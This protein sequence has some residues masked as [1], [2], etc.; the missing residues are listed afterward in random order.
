MKQKLFIF[1]F[2][3]LY[4]FTLYGQTTQNSKVLQQK[5]QSADSVVLISHEITFGYAVT[6]EKEMGDTTTS[7][8][9]PVPAFF[10]NGKLNSAIINER[11]L[12]N[13][14]AKIA[15][16]K[17][18]LRPVLKEKRTPSTFDQPRHSIIIYKSKEQSYIDICFG[19]GKI[20]TSNDIDFSEFYMDEEKWT[21]L[22]H[23]FKTNGLTALF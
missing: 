4:L 7:K 5:I 16:T 21:R 18:L 6:P 19:C 17:I 10:I 11:I 12:L 8:E 22:E 15:L 20:H 3:C 13:D 9:I 1:F 2:S 23:F 14:P